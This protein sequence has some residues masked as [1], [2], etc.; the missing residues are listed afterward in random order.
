MDYKVNITI[1]GVP[2]DDVEMEKIMEKIEGALDDL[3]LR[4]WIGIAEPDANEKLVKELKD[5]TNTIS[6]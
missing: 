2:D 6:K 1:Y 5:E 3:R 4:Y